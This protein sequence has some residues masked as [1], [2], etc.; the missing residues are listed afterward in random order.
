MD[1]IMR[2]VKG[3]TKKEMYIGNNRTEPNKISEYIYVDDLA[4]FAK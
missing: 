3:E 2:R 1:D 4:L